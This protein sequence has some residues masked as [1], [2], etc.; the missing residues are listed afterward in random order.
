MISIFLLCGFLLDIYR[1]FKGHSEWTFG[2]KTAI[3]VN[4]FSLFECMKRMREIKYNINKNKDLESIEYLLDILEKNDYF[5]SKNLFPFILKYIK[6]KINFAIPYIL[7]DALSPQ[8]INDYIYDYYS[9]KKTEKK[10][11]GSGVDK[12][13]KS[14]H[15]YFKHSKNKITMAQIMTKRI[16]S[17]I[18]NNS[19]GV[20]LI[21]K[22]IFNE[23]KKDR[24]IINWNPDS[25]KES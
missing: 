15:K 13:L 9:D 25:P 23:L 8:V 19:S 5:V 2:Q 17:P 4:A 3:S 12:I 7:E 1:D 14:T 22:S 20:Q 16:Y 6:A 11:T 24:R 10:I 18:N 21:T